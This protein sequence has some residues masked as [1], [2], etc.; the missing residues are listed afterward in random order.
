MAKSNHKYRAT[1]YLGKE[2]FTELEQMAQTF[3]ISVGKLAT[4]MFKTGWEMS[5]AIDKGVNL[6]NGK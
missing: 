5:K 3:N 4:I 2:I 1:I 6:I